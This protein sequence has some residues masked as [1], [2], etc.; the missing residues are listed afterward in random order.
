MG[1]KA[2]S[3]Q[4]HVVFPRLPADVA[5]NWSIKIEVGDGDGHQRTNN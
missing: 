3:L 2:F 4:S 1:G 5:W